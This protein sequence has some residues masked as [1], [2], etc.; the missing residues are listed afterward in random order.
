MN[1][2]IGVTR[3]I[4]LPETPSSSVFSSMNEPRPEFRYGL[5]IRKDFHLAFLS[6]FLP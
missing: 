3:E 1:R 2:M 5:Q 4:E 6:P